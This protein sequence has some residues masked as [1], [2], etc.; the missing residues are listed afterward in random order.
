[1]SKWKRT[2]SNPIRKIWSCRYL[3][4]I[5]PERLATMGYDLDRLLMEL[6]SLPPSS[7]ML[8]SDLLRGGYG[9]VFQFLEAGILKDKLQLLPSWHR[10]HMHR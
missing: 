1:M 4:W 10:I 3:R 8:G 2:L 7:R 9:L 6:D 5:G